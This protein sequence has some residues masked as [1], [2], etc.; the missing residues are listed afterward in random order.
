[1]TAGRAADRLDAAATAVHSTVSVACDRLAGAAGA[2]ALAFG[3]GADSL[4][5][6]ADRAVSAELA[7]A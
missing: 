2:V 3:N 1:M 6:A 5:A 7:A 4:E